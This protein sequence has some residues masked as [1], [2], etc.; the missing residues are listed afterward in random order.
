[1]DWRAAFGGE[2]PPIAGIA[3]MTD[4]DNTG[5]TARSWYGDI[6]LRRTWR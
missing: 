6:A 1:A 5:E 2:A 3:I 4:T